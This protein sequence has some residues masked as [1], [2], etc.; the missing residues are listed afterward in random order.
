V[1][2]SPALIAAVRSAAPTS[3]RLS[4]TTTISWAAWLWSRTE[5][6]VQVR[7]SQRSSVWLQITTETATGSQAGMIGAC[8][9]AW[10][11]WCP[12]AWSGRAIPWLAP[13]P[14]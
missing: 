6:T 10:L 11:R 13:P 8:F 1:S 2:A 14:P 5:A 4:I 9:M 7:S 12:A 3:P